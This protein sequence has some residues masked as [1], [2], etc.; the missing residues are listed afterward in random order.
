MVLDG[1]SYL[2]YYW[3]ASLLGAHEDKEESDEYVL[4]Y[5]LL[6]PPNCEH[7]VGKVYE[8]KVILYII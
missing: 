7:D 6:F 8:V 3:Y 1:I 5:F 2:L 4:E